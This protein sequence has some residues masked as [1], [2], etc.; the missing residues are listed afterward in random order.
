LPDVCSQIAVE[1][2]S[3]I[4]KA[5]EGKFL[6]KMLNTQLCVIVPTQA[7]SQDVKSGCPKCAIGSARMNNLRL[8]QDIT[9]LKQLS[10]GCLETH[11]ARSLCPQKFKLKMLELINKWNA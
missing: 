3:K 11:L 1:L 5:H 4:Q 10:T 6:S 8:R 9:K 2:F 7:F